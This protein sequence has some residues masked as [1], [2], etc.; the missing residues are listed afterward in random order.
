MLRLVW[1]LLALHLLPVLS[2]SSIPV[3][4]WYSLRRRCCRMSKVA[5]CCCFRTPD[6]PSCNRKYEVV[7]AALR[8]CSSQYITGYKIHIHICIYSCSVPQDVDTIR[9]FTVIRGEG[10]LSNIPLVRCTTYHLCRIPPS[11]RSCCQMTLA[12]H[13]TKSVS[14]I[15]VGLPECWGV[16][17]SMDCEWVYPSAHGMPNFEESP[18]VILYLHG[19]DCSLCDYSDVSAVSATTRLSLMP[20]SPLL[21]LQPL[22]CL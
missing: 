12:P 11:R 7:V 20:L 14:T 13:Q 1:E 21:S 6:H 17:G 22:C 10:A 3:Q 16:S 4:L 18:R 2:V 8:T 15:D 19:A 5:C 9:M